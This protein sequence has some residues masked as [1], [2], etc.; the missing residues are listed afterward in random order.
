MLAFVAAA[1]AAA[2]A[3]DGRLLIDMV[4]N[5]PGDAVGWQQT[6]YRNPKVLKQ[7]GYTARALTGELSGTQAVDFHS[8]GHDFFPA[9]SP[10][11]EWLD[12]YAAGVRSDVAAAVDAGIKVYF[13][14]DLVV[15]P[16]PVIAAYPNCTDSKG[17][18]VW[19]D[20][21]KT[22]VRVL[23]NE[24]FAAFPDC[25]GWIIREGETYTYDTPYHRGNSPSNNT[26]D[27]WVD[28]ITFMREVVS[29]QHGKD[30]FVRSWDNWPSDAGYYTAMTDRIPPHPHLYFSI[31]HSP[32][33][34]TRP[35]GWNPQLGVGKHQQIVEVELQRE[36]EGKAAFP[37]YVMDGVI[38]GF[39]EMAT[40]IGLSSVVNSTQLKGLWT[41][42][43][44][45]G[46][47][48]PYLHG[49][50]LWVDLHV[51]VISKWWQGRGAVSE[52][53]V[54]RSVCGDVLAGCGG[55]RCCSALRNISQ[56]AAN[57]VLHGMWGTVGSRPSLWTRD[58]RIGGM[59]RV[60]G[61][62]ESLGNDSGLWDASLAE[63]RA[64]RDAWS[65]IAARFAADIEPA[66]TDYPQRA[67]AAASVQYGTRFF[68]ILDASWRVLAQG[69]RKDRKMQYDAAALAAAI[70]D[71]DSAFGAYRAF[72]LVNGFAPSL[73]HPYYLCLGTDCTGA[74]D[75]PPGAAPAGIGAS[76]DKYR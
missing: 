2:A 14:V 10:Q 53:N 69:Y 75:P 76:V 61:H 28:F 71:Y 40:K 67:F 66:L 50:E 38:D 15:L 34:F 22:L 21:T 31:K 7:L 16:T 74:F 13:F 41:W 47:W 3:A 35:A 17:K 57:S 25:D 60:K 23:V 70:A 55:A 27:R 9:G 37:N 52:E 1:A 46:W 12:A 44:G 63:M 58:D 4:Q 51:A 68:E 59:D 30:L 32:G 11:R 62:W 43:R 45:G 42:S 8:L 65:G 24:T 73:Y 5:N 39:P 19:N 72:G 56:T 6:K 48:G 18:I 64:A 49:N 26:A 54:F 33:D 36:Y 29:V 20:V